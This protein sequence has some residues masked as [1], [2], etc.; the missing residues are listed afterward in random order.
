MEDEFCRIKWNNERFI[1]GEKGKRLLDVLRENGIFLS[2]PCGGNGK[3]GKCRVF[4]DGESRLAC[5]VRVSKD[6]EVCPALDEEN[7]RAVSSEQRS[8]EKV[9]SPGLAIDLG[10][11]TIAMA[12][13][14]LSNGEVAEA[15]SCINH[16]R[17]YG[18]DVISRI[19]AACSGRALLL[20]G[21]VQK[22]IMEEAEKLLK[23][24][25]LSFTE[26]EKI[27]VA[28]NTT[29]LHLLMGWQTEGLA[30]YPFTPYCIEGGK[31]T[32]MEVFGSECSSAEVWIL[33]GISAFVGA[34]IVAGIETTGICRADTTQAIIDLGTNGE[35]V[36]GSRKGLIVTSTAAGTAFEGGNLRY[37]MPGTDGAISHV[38]IRNGKCEIETIGDAAAKGIC[39]SGLI[40]A[41]YEMR[42]CDIIDRSGLLADDY[43]RGYVLS[44]AERK[45]SVTQEDVQEFL[46]AKSAVR[47]GIEMLVSRIGLQLDELSEV[48]I[49]GGFGFFL[50][51][52]KAAGIGL[53]PYALK[54]RMSA[55]GN[56]SLK[57]AIDA[58]CMWNS[59]EFD[60]IRAMA[61]S[62]ELAE[63]PEF[64]ERYIE[65]MRLELNE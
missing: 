3:C 5:D 16:Q 42:K 65:N 25:G 36:V 44:D 61:E 63:I 56:S 11:T 57:G 12:V 60:K 19:D 58:L 13:V 52:K 55:V 49:A 29:M 40:D 38:E 62:F 59:D 45:I 48:Y 26:L 18:A 30:A 37:G 33:P 34:D 14:D 39:G 50:N 28:G 35:M 27:S 6:I 1:T 7:I 32:F 8:F 20:R 17:A 64:N 22:D 41:V 43:R 21:I 53:L 23:K 54:G 15:G 24:C 10:T 31:F 9:H 51:L 47:T 4:V 46:L 2:A